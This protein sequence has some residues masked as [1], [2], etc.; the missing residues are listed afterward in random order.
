MFADLPSDLEEMDETLG[1]PPAWFSS[2]YSS[3][4]SIP[5]GSLTPGHYS[6]G[7]YGLGDREEEITNRK[8]I[9]RF[10]SLTSCLTSCLSNQDTG[11]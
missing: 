4:T 9:L 8:V 10:K 2:F 5:Y 7:Y 1:P 3:G 11:R 6:Q